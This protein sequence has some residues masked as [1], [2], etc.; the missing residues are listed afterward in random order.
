[1]KRTTSNMRLKTEASKTAKIMPPPNETSIVICRMILS[2]SNSSLIAK[3]DCI[4]IRIRSTESSVFVF[5]TTQASLW[6]LIIQ[7]EPNIFCATT[8]IWIHLRNKVTDKTRNLPSVRGWLFKYA[9]RTMLD[10]FL[11][12]RWVLDRRLC[13]G[14]KRM[15]PCKRVKLHF[16]KVDLKPSQRKKVDSGFIK[17]L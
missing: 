16:G 11:Q 13:L 8:R 6:R 15:L 7:V 3:H 1:M 5:G 9:K 2:I 17:R 14:V 12:G 4:I 10:S